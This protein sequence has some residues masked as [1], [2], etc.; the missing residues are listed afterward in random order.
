M[1]KQLIECMLGALAVGAYTAL[2]HTV[3]I[4]IVG[5]HPISGED[6]MQDAPKQM[7]KELKTL[8][9]LANDTALWL[10]TTHILQPWIEWIEGCGTPAY[11]A[12]P[13]GVRASLW[14]DVFRTVLGRSAFKPVLGPLLTDQGML[15]QSTTPPGV[16]AG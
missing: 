9:S 15:A 5:D 10:H 3:V 11:S 12:M 4:P 8:L 2:T 7:R 16:T 1:Q 14:T 13:I 6:V